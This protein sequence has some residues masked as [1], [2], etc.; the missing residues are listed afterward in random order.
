MKLNAKK[1]GKI[2]A[3]PNRN[4]GRFLIGMVVIERTTGLPIS[5]FI[6]ST[7]SDIIHPIIAPKM[8]RQ[9]LT[10]RI[11]FVIES[12]EIRYKQLLELSN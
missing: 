7:E 6:S 8:P 10:H 11:S 12:Y 3:E 5:C 1:F 4:F 9:M 2:F